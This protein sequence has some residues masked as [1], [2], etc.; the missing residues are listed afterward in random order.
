MIKKLLNSKFKKD[1]LFSYLTQAITI[2][3][4]FVELFFINRYFGIV[5][6]GQLAVIMSTAGI[7]SALLTARSSEAVTRFFKREE[8]NKNYENAKFILIIGLSIDFITAIILVFLIYSL[9]NF[10]AITFLKNINLSNEIIMYSFITFFIFLRG[11]FIGYLQSKEMFVK[12]NTINII[13]SFCKILGLI[14]VIFIFKS[15]TLKNVIYIFLIASIISFIYT[16]FIFIKSYIY[17]YYQV[18]LKINKFILKEY[19][20]FNIKIFFSST[21]KAGN[22]NVDN[23][24]ISYFLNT[25]IVGIYQTL[26]KVLSPIIIVAT[27]FSML[28]YPKLI[29]YFETKQK[30]KFKNIITKISLYLFLLGIG[31]SLIAY[32][33]LN[34]IF[35]LMNIRFEDI[36]NL[37][38]IL[39][40]ILYILLSQMWWLRAFSN[41]VNPNYS[42]YMNLFATFYQLIITVLVTKYFAFIGM[43]VSLIIMNILILSFWL[44][45]GYKYVYIYIKNLLIK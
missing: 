33:F 6:Y 26:K 15:Y 27:P 36:Y 5:I 32:C 37:Y 39:L 24:I 38:Y 34:L 10:I 3:F 22:Q 12:I 29:H 23:L 19:W 25:E 28:V 13:E 17:E 9:A 4:G 45:K 41:T 35:G 16:F 11:T 8:L 43:L 20:N 31:Y 2:S 40:A 42:I 14:V 1:L 44:R 18:K 21:L 7:F 30:E